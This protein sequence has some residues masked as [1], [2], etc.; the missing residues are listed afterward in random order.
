MLS[1]FPDARW[2]IS[3][4]DW[5]VLDRFRAL[6]RDCEL[7]LLTSFPGD[8]LIQRASRIGHVATHFHRARLRIERIP[9]QCHAPAKFPPRISAYGNLD[10]HS[11]VAG[12]AVDFYAL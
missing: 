8:D 2:A 5:N 1:E 4:F 12:R 6:D 7:W 3:S 11:S 9:D 10:R